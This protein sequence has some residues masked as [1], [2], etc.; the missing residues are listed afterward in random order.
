MI[1]T[2][3]CELKK[4]KYKRIIM[5]KKEFKTFEMP[6][7]KVYGYVQ[8]VKHGDTIWISGQLGHNAEGILVE[9]MENQ[10]RQTYENISLLLKAY[11]LDSDSVTEEVIYVTNM[12]EGF[13]GRKITGPEF[14][15]EKCIVA[16]TIVGVTELALPGQK[17]EIK[18]IAKI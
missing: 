2:M 13:E 15:G 16:S 14:Y 11:G 7:E 10:F 12:Q 17:V 5:S 3:V 8:S 1:K 18:I 9:G 6:W 4:S